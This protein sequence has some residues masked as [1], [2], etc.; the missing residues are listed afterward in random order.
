MTK[1]HGLFVMSRRVEINEG[2]AVGLCFG[3]PRQ[4]PADGDV[5]DRVIR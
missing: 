4:Q 3:Q 2:F 5:T 1:R